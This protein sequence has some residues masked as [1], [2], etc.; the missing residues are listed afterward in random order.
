VLSVVI[1]LSERAKPRKVQV[2]TG[3][4]QTVVHGEITADAA[5]S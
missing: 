1:P 2:T 4:E 3:D 5:S